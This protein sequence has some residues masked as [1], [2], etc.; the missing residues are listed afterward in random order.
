MKSGFFVMKALLYELGEEHQRQIVDY[1]IRLENGEHFRA[2]LGHVVAHALENSN[3]E[4]ADEVDAFLDLHPEPPQVTKDTVKGE[5]KPEEETEGYFDITLTEARFAR[6]ALAKSS[7][8]EERLLGGQLQGCID[9]EHAYMKGMHRSKWP[10]V[11]EAYES[12]YIPILVQ[13]QV[14]QPAPDS[15]VAA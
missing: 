5:P 7:K 1:G 8:M 11:R 3:P 10:Q 15:S 6:N 13:Q 4:R 9:A 14:E 12:K 2:I